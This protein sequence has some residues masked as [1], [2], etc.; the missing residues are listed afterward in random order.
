[1]SNYFVVKGRSLFAR[2]QWLKPIILSTQEAEIRKFEVQSQS[3]QIV[4]ETLS[5]KNLSQK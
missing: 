2:H 5:G 3:R 1:M 4:Q